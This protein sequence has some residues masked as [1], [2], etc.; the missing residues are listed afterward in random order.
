MRH[1]TSIGDAGKA[2]FILMALI[3][4]IPSNLVAKLKFHLSRLLHCRFF[5]RHKNDLHF[6]LFP[7]PHFAEIITLLQGWYCYPWLSWYCQVV[8]LGLTVIG[9]FC[10]LKPQKWCEEVQYFKLIMHFPNKMSNRR[11]SVSWWNMI[12]STSPFGAI[13]S[14]PWTWDMGHVENMTVSPPKLL[15]PCVHLLSSH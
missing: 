1:C 2:W 11:C 14:L 6:S 13:L 8:I 4:V 15:N 9:W 3:S 5:W 12:C 7:V 10:M